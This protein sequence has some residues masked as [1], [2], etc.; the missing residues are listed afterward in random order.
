MCHDR[1]FDKFI[2]THHCHRGLNLASCNYS[3]PYTTPI[4]SLDS[5][6]SSFLMPRPTLARLRA[7]SSYSEHTLVQRLSALED[8]YDRWGLDFLGS[9]PIIQLF[10]EDRAKVGVDTLKRL[11]LLA[12]KHPSKGPGIIA[13]LEEMRKEKKGGRRKG[14]LWIT[15]KVIDEALADPEFAKDIPFSDEGGAQEEEEGGVEGQC[16]KPE[17]ENEDEADM[18]LHTVL[19]KGQIKLIEGLGGIRNWFEENTLRAANASNVTPEV[20][21]ARMIKMRAA[22][23]SMLEAGDLI[24]REFLKDWEDILPTPMESQTNTPLGSQYPNNNL[25]PPKGTKSR[26]Q[27]PS[28]P[29]YASS[30]ARSPGQ[31]PLRTPSPLPHRP[32]LQDTNLRRK[33]TASESVEPEDGLNEEERDMVRIL[34]Y[35]LGGSTGAESLKAAILSLP[36]NSAL[37][38]SPESANKRRRFE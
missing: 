11:N 1:D 17:G 18:D 23:D 3:A 21:E 29:R 10:G 9:N 6:Q 28:S 24:V 20:T 37:N 12:E 13:K 34:S 27:T 7:T 5:F 8:I 38:T 22:F 33:A 32:V 16:A 26:S 14:L 4:T 25:S 15:K 19:R 36:P 31:S 35:F 2:P 30:S